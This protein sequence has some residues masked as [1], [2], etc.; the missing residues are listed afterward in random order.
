VPARDHYAHA[1]SLRTG[2]TSRRPDA[3]SRAC[4]DQQRPSWPTE[5]AAAKRAQA[6]VRERPELPACVIGTMMTRERAARHQSRTARDRGRTGY[7]RS[8]GALGVVAITAAELLHP[9]G[10]VQDAR[11]PGVKRVAR[12]RD[13]DVDD[14]IG[15]AVLPGDGSLAGRSR[16]G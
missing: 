11:L 16:P 1:A 3:A 10:R 9:A 15:T 2:T 13:L 5:G 12:R 4:C 6:R 7:L 14:G 8:S